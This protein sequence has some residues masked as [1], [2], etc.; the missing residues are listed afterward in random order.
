MERARAA[1]ERV[2]PRPTEVVFN[3]Y[4]ERLQNRSF[5]IRE[6]WGLSPAPSLKFS[7]P[8][9]SD[10]VVSCLESGRLVSV[11]GVKEFTGPSEVVLDDGEVLHVDAII[12]C[13]GYMADFSFLDPQFDPTAKSPA[14]WNELQGSRGRPLPRLYKNIFSLE[15]P[16]SLAFIGYV[17]FPSPAFQTQDLASMALAQIWKGSSKMPSARKMQ[18]EVEA[19]ERWMCKLARRGRVHP[20]WVSWPEWVAWANRAAGTGLAENLGW[21]VQGWRFWAGERELYRVVVDGVYTPHLYRLFETGKRKRWD[22]AAD[23]ILRVNEKRRGKDVDEK[24]EETR[25][26]CFGRLGRRGCGVGRDT[27]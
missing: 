21:G 14:A 2:L 27:T 16:E 23:E 8:V 24:G 1:L 12:W 26:L 6:E 17:A 25:L 5:E 18:R 11:P 13:T 15:R 10:T 22:R 7:M 9:I 20:A 19:H 3:K 4:V